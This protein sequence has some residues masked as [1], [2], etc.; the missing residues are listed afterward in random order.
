VGAFVSFQAGTINI[1]N[2][3]SAGSV[4]LGTTVN[5]D[6]CILLI[7]RKGID[8][9]C[10]N[11]DARVIV[12]AAGTTVTATRAGTTGSMDIDFDLYED[13]G[14]ATQW[15]TITQSTTPVDTAITAITLARTIAIP[16]GSTRSSTSRGRDDFVYCSFTSTTNLRTTM[17]AGAQVTTVVQ[18]IEFESGLTTSVNQYT[19]SL[20]AAT[21]SQAITSVDTSKSCV[22]SAGWNPGSATVTSAEVHSYG[23][24]SSTSV[25]FASYTTPGAAIG[26]A[27][28]VVEWANMTVTSGNTTVTTTNPTIV[29]GSAPTYGTLMF[30]GAYGILSTDNADDTYDRDTFGATLSSNTWTLSRV[31][32]DDTKLRYDAWDWANLRPA[33]TSNTKLALLGAGT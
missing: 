28:W 2:G 30:G 5:R 4:T 12:S 32:A 24:D 26:Y 13:T 29:L 27:I 1:A 17:N 21:G 25:G 18:V 22:F 10:T 6:N 23:L 7:R 15:L 8:N 9:S 14:L 11:S 3:A 19:G 33:S 16:S 31:T 20:S